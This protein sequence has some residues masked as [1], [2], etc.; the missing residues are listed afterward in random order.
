MVNF[1]SKKL[2]QI[3]LYYRSSILMV[4]T[5][6]LSL[7][8]HYINQTAGTTELWFLSQKFIPITEQ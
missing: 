8:T 3:S 6:L 2:Q 1:F 5:F 7:N 4:H